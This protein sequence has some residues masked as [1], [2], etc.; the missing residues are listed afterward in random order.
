[1]K[2]LIREGF[3]KDQ[4]ITSVNEALF[5]KKSL[6]EFFRMLDTTDKRNDG[7]TDAQQ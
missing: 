7:S 5:K 3:M 6:S 2:Y 4:K 1:M